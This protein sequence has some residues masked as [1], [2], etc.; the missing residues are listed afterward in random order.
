MDGFQNN[1]NIQVSFTETWGFIVVKLS[2]VTI[3]FYYTN[4]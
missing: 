2:L 1:F 3:I 4:V